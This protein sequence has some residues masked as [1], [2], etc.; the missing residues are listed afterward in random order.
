MLHGG[1]VEGKGHTKFRV[2]GK[3]KK[4]K[5]QSHFGLTETLKCHCFTQFIDISY[6]DNEFVLFDIVTV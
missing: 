3:W 4:G 5:S 2:M 1:K 6:S